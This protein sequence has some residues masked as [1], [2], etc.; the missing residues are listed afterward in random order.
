MESNCGSSSSATHTGNKP[1]LLRNTTPTAGQ[2]SLRHGA[3]R[4]R[5]KYGRTTCVPTTVNCIMLGSHSVASDRCGVGQSSQLDSRMLFCCLK[6][7]DLIHAL[8]SSRLLCGLRVFYLDDPRYAA[9]GGGCCQRVGCRPRAQ[10]YIPA[11]QRH[12]CQRRASLLLSTSSSLLLFSLE[13]LFSA[14][15][16]RR[17]QLMMSS[18]H[19]FAWRPCLRCPCC[20]MQKMGS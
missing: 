15:N 12:C 10:L 3:Q 4:Y 5:L 18:H 14:S 9:E 17:G 20:L 16:R 6:I 19:V 8:L 7:H 1:G 2:D 13:A 11:K